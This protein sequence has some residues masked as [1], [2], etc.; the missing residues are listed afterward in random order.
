MMMHAL[1]NL[2]SKQLNIFD[3]CRTPMPRPIDFSFRKTRATKLSMSRD[4]IRQAYEA[5]IR[6]AIPQKILLFACDK[7]EAAKDTADGFYSYSQ[8]LLHAA[9]TA[10]TDSFFPF[11]TISEAH[12]LAVSMMEE[13]DPSTIRHPQICSRAVPARRELPLAVNADFFL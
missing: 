6:A 1:T 4:P 13:G 12:D 11:A 3:C 7:G 5:R 2:A 8:Y 10:A 9:Q